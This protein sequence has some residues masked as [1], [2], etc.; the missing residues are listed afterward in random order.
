M[1]HELKIDKDKIAR[2]I[3]RQLV[4]S[5]FEYE[6]GRGNTA[7][8]IQTFEERAVKYYQGWE[9]PHENAGMIPLKRNLFY[10]RINRDV[11]VILNNL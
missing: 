1:D 8:E 2:I 6:F 11:A 9:E 7:E 5:N 4:L 3:T 10:H